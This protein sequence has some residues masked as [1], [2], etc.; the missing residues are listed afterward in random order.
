[1][2]T[3]MMVN[4]LLMCLTLLNLPRANPALAERVTALRNRR[5]QL[6][7]GIAGTIVLTGFLVVHVYK[8]LSA[9]VNAWY[10]HSTWVWLVVMGLGSGV[11]LMRRAALKREGVDLADR[12]GRLPEE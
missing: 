8:D 11:F 3:A 4:F 12:F 2:V 7:V 5:V 10:F 6:L 9:S 1:M